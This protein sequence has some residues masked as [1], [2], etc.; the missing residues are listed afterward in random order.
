MQACCESLGKSMHRPMFYTTSKWLSITENSWALDSR[1]ISYWGTRLPKRQQRHR[2][3][4][5]IPQPYRWRRIANLKVL[6]AIRC[7]RVGDDKRLW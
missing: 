5:R 6:R 1:F 2:F 4:Q 7:V 3:A